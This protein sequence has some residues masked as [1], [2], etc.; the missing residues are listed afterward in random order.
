L[1]VD[2]L[3]AFDLPLVF[4][5]RSYNTTVQAE[6][7][8]ARLVQE[9]VTTPKQ[10]WLDGLQ[11]GPRGTGKTAENK[12]WR[13]SSNTETADGLGK[14]PT[15]EGRNVYLLGSDGELNYGVATRLAR[16]LEYV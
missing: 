13:E 16:E 1:H 12:G 9:K 3:N 7:D 14:W 4:Q 2:G 8:L 10:R 6:P 5:G 11:G 15:L